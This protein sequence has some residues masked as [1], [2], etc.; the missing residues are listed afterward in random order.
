MPKGIP[1]S[2]LYGTRCAKAY[3]RAHRLRKDY[4][5][6]S[7]AASMTRVLGYSELPMIVEEIVNNLVIAEIDGGMLSQVSSDMCRAFNAS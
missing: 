3:E 6:I 4:F 1:G 7:H 5:G 2:F